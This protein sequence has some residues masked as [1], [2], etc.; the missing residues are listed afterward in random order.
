M[1]VFETLSHTKKGQ[2]QAEQIENVLLDVKL[3]SLMARSK[4]AAGLLVNI[5]K[6][7]DVIC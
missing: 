5:Q 6:I 2:L 7:K 1:R 4:T 3:M